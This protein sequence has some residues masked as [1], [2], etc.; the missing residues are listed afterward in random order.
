MVC[1]AEWHDPIRI[2]HNLTFHIKL[3]HD[4]SERLGVLS[5]Q[6]QILPQCHKLDK[7]AYQ[8][9]YTCI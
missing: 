3:P 2:E 1:L 9:R 7:Q 5:N 8:N 4:A 6:N